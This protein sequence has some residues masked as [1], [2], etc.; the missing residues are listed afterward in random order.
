MLPDIIGLKVVAIKGF[1]SD[2]R[3]KNVTPEY[4]LFSDKETFIELEDQD[5]YSYHDCA[6]SAKHINVKQS[7]E[8]WKMIMKNENGHYPD[9]NVEL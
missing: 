6:T 9:A 8:S 7:L 4:I 2:R 3:Y 1:Q 5:Y